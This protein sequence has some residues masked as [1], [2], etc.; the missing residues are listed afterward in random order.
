MPMMRATS[1]W[2]SLATTEESVVGCARR[3]RVE[4][5]TLAPP[6]SMFMIAWTAT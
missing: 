6:H 1:P 2:D 4:A 3:L 5:V